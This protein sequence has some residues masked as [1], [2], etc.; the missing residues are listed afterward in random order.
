MFARSALTVSKTTTGVGKA[1]L[2]NR[3]ATPS[4]GA[5]R[6]LN[7]HEYLSMDLMKQHGIATPAG[8]VASTPEEA[9]NDF[10][11]KLNHGGKSF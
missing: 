9:E 10:I 5:I 2:V 7:L 4:V 3:T 11:N 1:L 6:N 8:Y